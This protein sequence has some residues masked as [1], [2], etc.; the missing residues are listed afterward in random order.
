MRDFARYQRA[1][2]ALREAQRDAEK[3]ATRL[4]ISQPGL[5]TGARTRA[6]GLADARRI[7]EGLEALAATI[8][9]MSSDA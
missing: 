7:V 3:E 6:D 1:L 2:H 4:E 9:T 8:I 5:A